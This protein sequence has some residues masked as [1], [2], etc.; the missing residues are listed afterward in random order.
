MIVVPSPVPLPRGFILLAAAALSL[1]PAGLA[2]A[3][4]VDASPFLA[5]GASAGPNGGAE[6]GALELR[7]IMSTPAGTR[8]CIY[9]PGKKVGTWVGVNERGNSFMIKSAD[10]AHQAVTVQSEGRTLRLMLQVSKVSALGGPGVMGAP[11]AQPQP[12][13]APG[14]AP[15]PT[16]ADEAARLAAVAEAVRARRQMREQAAQGG[17]AANAAAARKPGP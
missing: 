17:D 16:P 15:K 14:V 8:Y 4:L 2:R 12:N 9:D 7:G 6:N 3:Q 13:G 1:L 5:P 11:A 10:L